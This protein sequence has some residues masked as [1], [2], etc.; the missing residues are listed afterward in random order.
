[1]K[2]AGWF[3]WAFGFSFSLILEI[4]LL[5]W[6]G[7]AIRRLGCFGVF[8]DLRCLCWRGRTLKTIKERIYIQVAEE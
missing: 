8:S 7:W 4:V 5:V 3:V 6:I 2:Q 1:M